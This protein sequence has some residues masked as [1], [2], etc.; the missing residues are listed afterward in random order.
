MSADTK[1]YPLKFE[2]ILKQKVWGGNKL[3]SIYHKES[4]QDSIGESWELSGVAGSISVIANGPLKGITLIEALEKYRSQLVGDK[5]YEH[6]GNEFPLLFKF[7]D[8]KKDL[9][10]QL[11]PNDELARARHNS[12]GKTEMWYILEAEEDARLILGFNR[13]VT[14]A[15][16]KSY[17]SE[18][19]I[20]DILHSEGVEKGD[21]F[22]IKTGTVHAIGAGIVLAEI[23]QTSDVT[24]RI[25]DWDRPGIDGEMRELHTD[26]AIDAIDYSVSEAKC[27]YRDM[28]NT[29]V[30][31]C[32]SPYFKTSKLLLTSNFKQSFNSNDTFTVYMCIEGEASFHCEGYSEIIRKGE[33][34]LI[35][36]CMDSLTIETENAIFLAVNIP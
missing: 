18:N 30:V 35:P 32:K 22:F 36:A 15:E 11:H 9:S 25:F 29:D 31:I 21:S 33:T 17:L 10:V 14:R 20:T 19:K 24:Y 1:L 26:L 4:N 6:F 27:S 16:Y 23:Q 34:V 28:E 3:A 8:A 7:I 13:N 5:V 2:P 12:F